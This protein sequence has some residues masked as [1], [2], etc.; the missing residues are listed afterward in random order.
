MKHFSHPCDYQPDKAKDHDLYRQ[1]LTCTGDIDCS[2]K[3][4]NERK[5]SRSYSSRDRSKENHW[6]EENEDGGVA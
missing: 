1:R 5:Q 6:N 3:R 2:G 4:Q